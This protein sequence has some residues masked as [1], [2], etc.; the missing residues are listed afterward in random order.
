MSESAD[1]S[2][3][4]AS[5][6]CK[7]DEVFKLWA[8]EAHCGPLPELLPAVDPEALPEPLLAMVKESKKMPKWIFDENSETYLRFK[9][10]YRIDMP[11]LI[12]RRDTN[13]EEPSDST[14]SDLLFHALPH[15]VYIF[16]R[17]S[18]LWDPP[19]S[20]ICSVSDLRQPIDR[21]T[22]H[23]WCEELGTNRFILR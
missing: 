4:P 9:S 1:S 8:D 14:A 3:S 21:L 7:N 2:I 6:V 10:L 5:I 22:S 13:T 16:N 20:Q 12:A 11:K 23:V 18:Q 19:H 17:Y 15:I